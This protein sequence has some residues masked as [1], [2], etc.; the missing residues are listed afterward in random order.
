MPAPVAL[1]VDESVTPWYHCISRCVRRAFLCGEGRDHR[2]QWIQDHLRRLVEIFSV[3]C[4]G[5]SIMD[6]HLHV[7]LRLDSVRASLWSA[8]EV[9]RRALTLFPL[10]D[11]SGKP[12]PITED[13]IARFASDES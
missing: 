5:F 4:A 3:D 1:V 9:A 11:V 7:L 12:L 2:K 8:D 6:N 13:R 10:R